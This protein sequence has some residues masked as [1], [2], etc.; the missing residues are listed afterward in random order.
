MS[1]EEEKKNKQGP[2][3]GYQWYNTNQMKSVIRKASWMSFEASMVERKHSLC[4]L[5]TTT[6]TKLA[7]DAFFPL[8]VSMPNLEIISESTQ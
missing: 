3:H 5:S 2:R 8:E 4:K 6:L 1:R 7:A